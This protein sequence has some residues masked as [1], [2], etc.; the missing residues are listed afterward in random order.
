MNRGILNFLNQL[1][2]GKRG[3]SNSFAE[4]VANFLTPNDEFEYRNGLLSNM[5]GSSAM[6]RMG[7]KTSYGTLGQANYAGN[8]PSTP[9]GYHMMP[10]GSMMADSEMSK[11]SSMSYGAQP[12]QPIEMSKILPAEI[13]RAIESSDFPDKQ[14][15]AVYLSQKLNEY[16]DGYDMI[17]SQPDALVRAYQAYEIGKTA[18]RALA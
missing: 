12:D 4:R 13:I 10:D 14:G 17:M 8:D 9:A 11:G 6:N 2:E 1:D 15:F 18:G 7:E 3:K 5:D 16:P